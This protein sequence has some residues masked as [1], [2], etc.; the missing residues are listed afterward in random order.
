MRASWHRPQ[1][2]RMLTAQAAN[3]SARSTSTSAPS[4]GRT[5][6]IHS[7]DSSEMADRTVARI[8]LG[9]SGLVTLAKIGPRSAIAPWVST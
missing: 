9:I 3:P 5:S 2:P 7:A 1:P 6:S 4:S 8:R